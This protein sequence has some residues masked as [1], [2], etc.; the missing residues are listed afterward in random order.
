LTLGNRLRKILQDALMRRDF[1]V[2]AVT[3]G[4]NRRPRND[5]F[6]DVCPTDTWHSNADVLDAPVADIEQKVVNPA[7]QL[8]AGID[9]IAVLNRSQCLEIFHI[10]T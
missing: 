8:A 4:P 5:D 1:P 10:L 7:D 3:P 2:A 9:N 6:A